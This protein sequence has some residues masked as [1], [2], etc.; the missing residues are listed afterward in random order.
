M[1]LVLINVLCLLFLA[2]PFLLFLWHVFFIEDEHKNRINRLELEIREA[3]RA[4]NVEEMRRL[5]EIIRN[6]S[7]NIP[8]YA[9][10]FTPLAI[11]VIWWG[12]V[13]FLFSYLGLDNYLY[14]MK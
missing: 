1:E 2:V 8:W 12:A 7:K 9:K 11:I 10:G 5:D 6:S 4:D 14:F 3:A 13:F